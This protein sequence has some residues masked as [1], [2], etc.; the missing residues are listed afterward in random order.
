MNCTS[1]RRWPTTL[2]IISHK[3][4]TERPNCLVV[5]LEK[6]KMAIGTKQKNAGKESEGERYA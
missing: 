3:A 5:Y 2:Y 4:N 6:K 1:S